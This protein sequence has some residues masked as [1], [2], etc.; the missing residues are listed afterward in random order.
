MSTI[1]QMSVEGKNVVPINFKINSFKTFSTVD[2]N[3]T[4]AIQGGVISFEIDLEEET[5]SESFFAQW[6]ADNSQ[7]DAVVDIA[8]VGEAS[9]FLSIDCRKAQCVQY[10][11]VVDQRIDTNTQNST[12]LIQIVSKNI[13]IGQSPVVLGN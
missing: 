7:K 3:L 5:D 8:A 12:V 13:S 2:G 10:T 11:L 4:S 9:R 1:A 6:F